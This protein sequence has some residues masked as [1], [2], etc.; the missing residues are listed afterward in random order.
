M[1]S[2]YLKNLAPLSKEPLFCLKFQILRRISLVVPF[3]LSC[4]VV[5]EQKHIARSFLKHNYISCRNRFR[6]SIMETVPDLSIGS[7][8]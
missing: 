6:L 8:V 4:L 5:H 1:F 2:L 7:I 3:L